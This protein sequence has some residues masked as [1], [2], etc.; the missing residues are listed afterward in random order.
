M[1]HNE[2]RYSRCVLQIAFE[3]RFVPYNSKVVYDVDL[4]FVSFAVHSNVRVDLIHRCPAPLSGCDEFDLKAK[5]QVRKNKIW[6]AF[7]ARGLDATGFSVILPTFGHASPKEKRLY[8][9]LNLQFSFGLDIHSFAQIALYK[10]WQT[11]RFVPRITDLIF[12]RR[13]QHESV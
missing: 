11:I 13:L 12:E 1:L 8:A 5:F 10:D 2:D 7:L 3:F 6:N 4:S 9:V